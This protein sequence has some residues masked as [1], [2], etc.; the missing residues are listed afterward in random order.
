MSEDSKKVNSVEKK[1]FFKSLK[2]EFKKIMWPDKPTVI[3]KSIVVV[4]ATAILA[5]VIAIL[6][7]LIGL[8]L[9]GLSQLIG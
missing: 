2:T 1:G 5:I 6:D 4:I 3:N 9:T 8:G 7:Y